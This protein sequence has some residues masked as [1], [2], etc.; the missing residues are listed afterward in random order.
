MS[1]ALSLATTLAQ[2]LQ[3]LRLVIPARQ[4]DALLEY[5][6][7]L[8]KWNAA[9]NLTAIRDPA[10]MLARHILDA[11]VALPWLEPGPLLDVGTGAGLPGIPLA[12][13]C[14]DQEFILLDSN[15]KKVRF[16]K[17]VVMALQIQNVDVV[18]SRVESY[19]APTA[20]GLIISRAFASLLDLL[21][22][23]RHL[24]P[25]YGWLAGKG[26]LKADEIAQ[27]QTIAGLEQDIRVELPGVTGDRHLV[28]LR[29]KN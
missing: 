24:Q 17:Q 4:Q 18:Q 19:E 22:A 10:D 20:I 29:L 21:T 3:Q 2:G 15:G 25:R 16:I 8:Q 5:V 9:Y 23:T 13:T 11:L 27:A 6:H 28:K 14:P 26:Q 7:L 12:L 1:P